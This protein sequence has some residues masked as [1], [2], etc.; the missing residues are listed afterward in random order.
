MQKHHFT[1]VK[2]KVYLITITITPV[3][4]VLHSI[5]MCQ[6][7]T[8]TISH[9]IICQH[10][11]HDKCLM[12]KENNP[13]M[14]SLVWQSTMS[15]TIRHLS[16]VKNTLSALLFNIELSDHQTDSLLSDSLPSS[17]N[18]STFYPTIL[19]T[20]LQHYQMHTLIQHQQN[21]IN[22]IVCSLIVDAHSNIFPVFHPS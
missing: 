13:L 18:M 15:Q 2:A 12:R 6:F 16:N 1:A 3:I 19:P 21:N 4:R 11:C 5:W 7:H 20:P 10:F 14:Q 17:I 8:W 9:A 22:S